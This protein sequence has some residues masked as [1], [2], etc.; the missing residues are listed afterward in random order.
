MLYLKESAIIKGFF[1]NLKADFFAN[2]RSILFT[3][4]CFSALVGME[5]AFQRA[6]KADGAS[7]KKVICL[8]SVHKA[9]TGE[10]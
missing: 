5:I 1:K 10:A 3:L 9:P 6:S 8:L 4:F 2:I 7:P